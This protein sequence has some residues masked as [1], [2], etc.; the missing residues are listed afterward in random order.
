MARSRHVLRVLE[1]RCLPLRRFEVLDRAIDNDKDVTKDRN[2]NTCKCIASRERAAT[3]SRTEKQKLVCTHVIAL[4]A[5]QYSDRWWGGGGGHGEGF[6]ALS[7]VLVS[8]VEACTLEDGVVFGDEMLLDFALEFVVIL[9]VIGGH[10]E[11][12]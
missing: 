6:R 7:G 4:L 5:M 1:V 10:A 11:A 3:V 2:L 8:L 12:G 9:D